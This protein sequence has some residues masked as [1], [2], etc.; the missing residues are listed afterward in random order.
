MNMNI[1]G[2]S[3]NRLNNVSFNMNK[4]PSL[5]GFNS[6]INVIPEV[7]VMKAN[8]LSRANVSEIPDIAEDEEEDDD[9]IFESRDFSEIYNPVIN[10]SKVRA[11][12]DIHLLNRYNSTSRFK[13]SFNSTSQFLHLPK[14][15][16]KKV[17]SSPSKFE[18]NY[19]TVSYRKAIP[20]SEWKP[21][22]ST[23][24]CKI[25]GKNFSFFLRRHH[26]RLCGFIFC[27][28]CCHRK[29]PLIIDDDNASSENIKKYLRNVFNSNSNCTT[30][31]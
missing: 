2:N 1:N 8:V 25:C 29:V 6:N 14:H 30:S 24:H 5:F 26:C 27:T 11:K 31:Q 13:G 23:K 3:N 21:D 18:T 17:S 7:E 9:D 22:N 15:L 28:Y 12:S 16:K 10:P 19:Y 4:G 20:R